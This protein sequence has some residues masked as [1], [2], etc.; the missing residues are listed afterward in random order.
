MTSPCNVTP[1]SGDTDPSPAGGCPFSGGGAATHGTLSRRSLLTYGLGALLTASG[2]ARLAAPSASA[3]VTATP[4]PTPTPT[5]G[6]A[7]TIAGAP[8]WRH[9]VGDPRG[10][11]IAK[12]VGRDKEGRFGLMF[13]NAPAFSPP[14][15]VLTD[16]AGQMTDPRAPLH[17]VSDP[18]DGRD[19]YGTP[20][21]YVYLGQFID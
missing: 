1:P 14:D 17:D 10:S 8:K 20:A 6:P 3:K 12:A 13:K 9:A 19:N 16:L 5:V 15:D 4:T 18:T 2:A 21:G 11:D 7:P